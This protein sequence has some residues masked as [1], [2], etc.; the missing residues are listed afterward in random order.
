MDPPSSLSSAGM[1]LRQRFNA[2]WRRIGA[3]G[4][5]APTFDDLIARYREPHRRYHTE[6]HLRFGL[7]QLD[8]IAALADD[9]DAVECAFFFHDAIYELTAP[10]NEVRSADLAASMLQAERTDERFIAEVVACIMATAPGQSPQTANERVMSDIDLAILGQ[11]PEAYERYERQVR[12]E[13][14]AVP[15]DVFWRARKEILRAFLSRPAIYST[16]P[17]RERYEWQAHLNLEA[18]VSGG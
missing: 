16:T 11:P 8:L 13:Y 15:D 17:F 12:E 6:E 18:S 2:V 14:G 10:D 1:D 7:E 3:S 4:D 9:A 5:P